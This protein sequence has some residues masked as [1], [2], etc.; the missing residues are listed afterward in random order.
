MPKVVW[1]NSQA[2]VGSIID[3]NAQKS[4]VLQRLYLYILFQTENDNRNRPASALKLP[5]FSS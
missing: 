2:T 3:P 5:K 1:L 4:L